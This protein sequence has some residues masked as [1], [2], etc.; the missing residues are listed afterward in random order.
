MKVLAI[1]ATNSRKG[2]NRQIIEHAMGLIEG[3]LLADATVEILDLNDYEMPVFSVERLE[4]GGVPEEGQRFYDKIGEADALVIS[5][6][7]HNGSYS[8]AWKNTYDWASR[9]DMAVYQGKKV[10]MFATSPGGRGGR[11]VLDA[12]TMVAPFFGAE[13]VG[14]LAIPS[15][16]ENFDQES[17][18]IADPELRAEFERILEELA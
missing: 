16:G 11:G 5:F 18:S 6:A 1:A 7:E 8:A 12:A 17:G 3:G 13:L 14:S 9:I 10:A 2:L 4:A 15:F